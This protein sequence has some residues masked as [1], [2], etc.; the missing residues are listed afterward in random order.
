M[1]FFRII[2]ISGEV[3]L[4]ILLLFG[5][6]FKVT[7]KSEEQKEVKA[8][9]EIQANFYESKDGILYFNKEL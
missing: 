6:F 8:K 1:K 7:S 4:V 9:E 2:I 3:L 5:I